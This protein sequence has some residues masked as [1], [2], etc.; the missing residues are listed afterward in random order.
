MTTGRPATLQPVPQEFGFQRGAA[1]SLQ[2]RR[3]SEGALRPT[4]QGIAP[5]L[6]VRIRGKLTHSRARAQP[7]VPSVAIPI[8][9]VVGAQAIGFVAK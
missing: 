9:P 7:D 3:A 6:T 1:V 8:A 4:P 2:A 5:G